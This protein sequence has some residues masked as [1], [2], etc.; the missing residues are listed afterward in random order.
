MKLQAGTY[1]IV[2]NSI[3]ES[4]MPLACMALWA[5]LRKQP[6]RTGSTMKHIQKE[7]GLSDKTSLKYLRMLENKNL[8]KT[9]IVMIKG[10]KTN[11]YKAMTP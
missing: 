2:P 5:I 7:T 6:F 3:L 8:V 1:T 9:N 4:G 11:F 10:N